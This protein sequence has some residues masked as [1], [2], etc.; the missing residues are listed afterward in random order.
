M[1]SVFDNYRNMQVDR[2]RQKFNAIQGRRIVMFEKCMNQLEWDSETS[3]D[4][5]WRVYDFLCPA[6]LATKRKANWAE[7]DEIIVKRAKGF[8]DIDVNDI[9]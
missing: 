7:E 2:N 1:S 5:S 9:Y 6:Q 4:V 8:G 3:N